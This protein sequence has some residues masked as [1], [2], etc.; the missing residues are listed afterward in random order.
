MSGGLIEHPENTG[1]GK[2]DVATCPFAN[3]DQIAYI[4][5]IETCTKKVHTQCFIRRIIEGSKTPLVLLPDGK[6][7]CTKKHYTEFL[8]LANPVKKYNWSND[9]KPET[10]LVTSNY[11]LQTWM[12]TNDNYEIYKGKN[13]IHTKKHW[14]QIVAAKINNLTLSERTSDQIFTR[15]CSWEECWRTTHDW[16]Q[17]T[18]QGVLNDP[19][20]DQEHNQSAFDAAVKKMCW[21]YYDLEDIFL[22]RCGSHPK[23]TTDNLFDDVGNDSD[24]A[25]EEE[26]DNVSNKETDSNT[27]SAVDVV[28]DGDKKLPAKSKKKEVAGRASFRTPSPGFASIDK[29]T[30]KIFEAS[31]STSE[32]RLVLLKEQL[33]LQKAAAKRT[34]WNQKQAEADFKYQMWIK[35]E[36]MKEKGISDDF[37]LRVMPEASFVVEASRPKR[38]APE[39]ASDS[40]SPAKSTRSHDQSKNK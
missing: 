1:H 26:D 24:E 6:V 33:E 20:Y 23:I 4:C 37:I 29:D 11:C 25:A 31:K 17:N 9:A 34:D 39:S 36:S 35:Y 32:A 5:A 19:K 40:D 18:G 7:A 21:F 13:G 3:K 16:I 27:Q 14:C 28:A 2:C 10:P 30:I 8:K 15:I 22:D 12:K 38:P